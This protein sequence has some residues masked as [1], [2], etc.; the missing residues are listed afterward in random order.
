[1]RQDNQRKAAEARRRVNIGNGWA[2]AEGLISVFMKVGQKDP[3]TIVFRKLESQTEDEI[4]DSDMPGFAASNVRIKSPNNV[5]LS[6]GSS[7]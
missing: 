2:M 6:L 1:M 4:E 5:M 3:H 7:R